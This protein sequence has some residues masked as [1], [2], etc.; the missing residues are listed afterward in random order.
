MELLRLSI[1]QTF[2]RL[3]M[4]TI[5]AKQT[6]ESP[7][8]TMNIRQK[9]AIMEIESHPGELTID[10]TAAWAALERPGNLEWKHLIYSDAKSIALQAI[11]KKVEDGNRMA[12][13]SNPANAFAE[14]AHQKVFERAPV[15]YSGD[16]SVLNVK[17]NYR[18]QA[19]DIRI[20]PQKAEIEYELHKP[21]VTY[22][23]GKVNLFVERQNTIDITVTPYD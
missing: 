19:P 10:S 17:L 7:P 21:E 11:A 22:I 3:G 8:G 2:G 5:N 18:V 20:E 6:M 12:Q 14:L 1:H 9:A 15:H 23:P 4:E 16:P 13:L